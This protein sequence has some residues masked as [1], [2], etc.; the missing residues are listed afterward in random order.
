M[1]NLNDL[2]SRILMISTYSFRPRTTTTSTT[3][4]E[5]ST[6]TRKPKRRPPFLRPVAKFPDIKIPKIPKKTTTKTEKPSST[7]AE[8]S[9]TKAFTVPEGGRTLAVEN[10]FGSLFVTRGVDVKKFLKLSLF[11]TPIS[12]SC[13]VPGDGSGCPTGNDGKP[14]N[15]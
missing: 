8:S 2:G 4:A 5:T 10:I 14:G 11:F 15:S 13:V 3:A 1:K 9:T 12:L 6:T 7:S